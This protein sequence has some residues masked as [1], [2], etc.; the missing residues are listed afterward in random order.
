M[1]FA[2]HRS[3]RLLLPLLLVW[4]VLALVSPHYAGAPDGL[5]AGGPEELERLHQ[6]L[7][8]VLD[9]PGVVYTDARED[10]GRLEIGVESR[11]RSG[12]AI[13]QVLERLGISSSQV[14]IV[15]TQP[16]IQ[17]ATLRDDVAEVGGV[18]IHF[19]RYLCTLG[20]NA[21]DGAQNSFITNSHCTSRQGGVEGT[22]YYQPQS[23]VNSTAI[24][25]EVE[26]PTY[27]R[28]GACPATR[29]C[30]Y[31]DAAR[32]RYAASVPFALG[33]LARTTAPNTGS[34]EISQVSNIA[35]DRSTVLGETVNKVGRTT[36]WTQGTVTGTCVNVNVS[37]SRL[38]LLCQNLVTA[39]VGPGDSGSPVFSDN[40]QLLGV[41]WGGNTNGTLF[42][43]SP[44]SGVRQ[45]LGQLVVR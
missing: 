2:K 19:S 42:V 4:G 16:L 34:L 25:T 5:A 44:I 9:I 41:L 8:S 33:A 24:G 39:G 15:E 35:G 32:V 28:G 43:F 31:S 27:F 1:G 6:R 17:M 26:D 21:V 37:G 3:I 22:T 38:T 23:N 14:S 36:G 40:D 30:R 12:A 10:L 11:G 13:A 20:F 7:A 45:E 18:Q 29:Q